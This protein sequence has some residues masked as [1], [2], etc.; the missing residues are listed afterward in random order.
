MTES[1]NQLIEQVKH[2][3]TNYQS[4]LN[5]IE[6]ESNQET[7]RILAAIR[8]EEAE[9]RSLLDEY[10]HLKQK[11]EIEAFQSS[12]N[13]LADFKQSLLSKIK[14]GVTTV[15][16]EQIPT[17][18][19]QKPNNIS[20][21]AITAKAGE[22][23]PKKSKTENIKSNTESNEYD[24]QEE[25]ENGNIITELIEFIDQ[26]TAQDLVKLYP[27]NVS[28]IVPGFNVNDTVVKDKLL[29][30]YYQR[31]KN[32][33]NALVKLYQKPELKTSVTIP[34]IQS[35]AA[36]DRKYHE[37]LSKYYPN[38]LPF[39]WYLVNREPDSIRY[40]VMEFA[41]DHIIQTN[42]LDNNNSPNELSISLKELLSMTNGVSLTDYLRD[43][44]I[45]FHPQRISSQNN[46]KNRYFDYIDTIIRK[47][48]T[49]EHSNILQLWNYMNKSGYHAVA[50]D[51]FFL[52][53][54]NNSQ[55][56]GNGN[57]LAPTSQHDIL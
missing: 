47:E 29:Q 16:I 55:Q 56:N 51:D 33:Y 14:S 43:I 10:R 52:T 34:D 37:F 36:K 44:F 15:N 22:E 13:Y 12:F 46:S 35:L 24:I 38:A 18:S 41:V 5:Q 3:L 42:T 54:P 11:N 7:E 9:I 40:V 53:A 25:V 27:A 39:F 20:D 50:S 23:T 2:N 31:N 48:A 32:S 8:A 26:I 49:L 4:Q 21:S 17:V 19:I 45:C 57:N 1:I 30:H 6:I 28:R